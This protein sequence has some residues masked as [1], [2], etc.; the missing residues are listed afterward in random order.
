MNSELYFMFFY[1]VVVDVALEQLHSRNQIGE[2]GVS[3]NLA[4]FFFVNLMSKICSICLLTIHNKKNALF[5]L[6]QS[7]FNLKSKD[8]LEV[9]LYHCIVCKMCRFL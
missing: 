4:L 6:Y 3:S 8:S 2:S 1:F 9:H 5:T 7:I